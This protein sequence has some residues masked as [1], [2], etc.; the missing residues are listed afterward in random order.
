MPFHAPHLAEHLRAAHELRVEKR[1]AFLDVWILRRKFSFFVELVERLVVI[2][3]TG[4]I[5]EVPA[6]A[7]MCEVTALFDIAAHDPFDRAAAA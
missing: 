2:A 5:V 1:A 7:D 6:M 4:L 3:R